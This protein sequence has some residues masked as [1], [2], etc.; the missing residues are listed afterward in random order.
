MPAGCCAAPLPRRGRRAAVGTIFRHEG[1]AE[2]L[3]RI[4]RAGRAGFYEGEVAEDLVASLRALG[5]THTLDDLAGVAADEVEPLS[6]DYRGHEIVELPPNGQGATA[7]LLARILAQ[8]ELGSLDPLGPERAH[9]EA[10]AT[11]LAYDARDR[12]VAER[13]RGSSTCCRT[14]PPPASRR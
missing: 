3:R 12:F 13:A 11:A 2:V 1:Q 7:L 4:A 6:A 10:E 8:F 9:L 5:G 14:T